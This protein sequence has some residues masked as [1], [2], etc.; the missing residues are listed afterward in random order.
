MCRKPGHNHE[1]K[2]C[3]DNP[4]NKNN[5][6]NNANERDDTSRDEREIEDREFNM[7]E[8]VE[9]D[10][11]L[12]KEDEEAPTL[13]EEDILPVKKEENNIVNNIR[14]IKKYPENVNNS[15]KVKVSCIFT[16]VNEKGQRNEYLGLLDTG[17]TKSLISKELVKKYRMKTQTDNGN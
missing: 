14:S 6:E 11:N 16:L 1:W 2:D 4:R 7:I 8:E 3:P 17:S 5:H 10:V 12:I 13:F 9:F 15:T